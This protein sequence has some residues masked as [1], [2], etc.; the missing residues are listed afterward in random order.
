VGADPR[1]PEKVVTRFAS[2]SRVVGPEAF[3]APT[4][5]G[6]LAGSGLTIGG[7]RAAE[8]DEAWAGVA[9]AFL[10]AISEASR[11]DR[12]SDVRITPDAHSDPP[13]APS[14][15]LAKGAIKGA[16]TPTAW[17]FDAD[18]GQRARR[19]ARSD[20]GSSLGVRSQGSSR[21]R[22]L[23]GGARM[24]LRGRLMGGRRDI[25]QTEPTVDDS[26]PGIDLSAAREASGGPRWVSLG[27]SY[28][29][30]GDS[31]DRTEQPTLSVRL[32]TLTLRGE[33]FLA[34]NFSPRERL[35]R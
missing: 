28:P 32:H 25:R 6:P 3:C 5:L 2:P 16:E 14:L 11:Q 20:E 9:E 10:E 33:R 4:S 1:D 17:V 26:D 13:Y 34:K 21:G 8:E 22:I 19:S 23:F 7:P 24:L 35:S 12:A 15:K 27:A 29:N 31:Q 18:R 30:P